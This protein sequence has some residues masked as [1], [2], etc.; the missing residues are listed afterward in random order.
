MHLPALLPGH[1]NSGQ[2]PLAFKTLS[3]SRSFVQWVLSQEVVRWVER[4][5][6]GFKELSVQYT[7]RCSRWTRATRYGQGRRTSPCMCFL[8]RWSGADLP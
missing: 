7:A 2:T 1:G 4:A 5:R 3:A 8:K 6:K